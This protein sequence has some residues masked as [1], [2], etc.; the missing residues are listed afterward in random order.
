MAPVSGSF[1]PADNGTYTVAVVNGQVADVAGNTVLGVTLGTFT[2]AVGTATTPTYAATQAVSVGSRPNSVAIADLNGDGKLDAVSASPTANNVSVRLGNGDGTFGAVQSFGLATRPTRAIVADINGDQKPDLV[3][4][5]ATNANLVVLIGNGDGTFQT[6]TSLPIPIGADAV[7]ATDLNGDG[8]VDLVAVLR[9][10]DVVAVL[11]NN[12]N[13]TFQA[14]Q[15]VAAGGTPSALVAVDLNAD[16]KPDIVT[17]N[18]SGVRVLLGNGDGTFQALQAFGLGV[19][20]GALTAADVNGDGKPDVITG[21]FTRNS[22]TVF[23]GTGDGT[24]QAPSSVLARGGPLAI[25]AVDVDNDGDLDLAVANSG[26]RD[27]TILL[28]NN[29][30]TFGN[31]QALLASD[32]PIGVAAGDL[33]ADG[34]VDLVFAS[35]GTNSTGLG[36]AVAN[37]STPTVTVVAVPSNVSSTPVGSLAVVFSQAV[38]GFDI[39]DITLTRNGGANLLTGAQ[40][41]TTGDSINFTIGNL[42]S[43]TAAEGSYTLTVGAGGSGVLNAQFNP[44]LGNAQTTFVIDTAGPGAVLTGIAT[45]TTDGPVVF[46]VTFTDASGVS[47]NSTE[48]ALLVTGPNG[49]SRVAS[50]TTILSS[51]G[52]PRVRQYF[53]N[54][55]DVDDFREINNGT[56][57]VSLIAGLVLDVLGNAATGAVLRTFI[58]SIDSTRRRRCCRRSRR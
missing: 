33:N 12:G 44:L 41:V 11:I 25:I 26:G 35:A 50:W 15:F 6:G 56:Y 1:S 7:V 45:L 49:F 16:N 30:G 9:L 48:N 37:W 28:G 58:V 17:S 57:T 2:V 27:G 18:A 22:V 19:S 4:A 36:V 54:G 39:S 42:A 40:T 20:H 5:G 32:F 46:T 47:V 10:S 14:A 38:T 43:L 51:N 53:I 23:L 31:E 8:K 13:G 55:S 24:L 21:N 52:S 29:D 3:T 34:K